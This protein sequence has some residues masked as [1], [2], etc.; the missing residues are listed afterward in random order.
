[1]INGNEYTQ[2]KIFKPL[3]LYVK[4]SALNP[5]HVESQTAE[6][7]RLE[8]WLEQRCVVR[9]EVRGGRL[10]GVRKEEM[11]SNPGRLQFI[12]P[13]AVHV[14]GVQNTMFNRECT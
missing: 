9:R 3:F 14:P 6:V 1:M 2:A 13:I 4:R 11:A 12:V 8:P 7:I 5:W 10:S